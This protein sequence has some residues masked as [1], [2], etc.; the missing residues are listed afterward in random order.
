MKNLEDTKV[1]IMHDWLV[2]LGGAEKT[3]ECIAE[4]F[5]N[6]DIYTAKYDQKAV[7]GT[8]LED[9]NIIGPKQT[10]MSKVS[11]YFFTFLM[12]P[13]FEQFD[14]NKYDI[15]ISEGTAWPKGALTKPNQL[16]ISYIHTPPRFLYGY[17]TESTKRNKWYFK[18]FFSYI[19]NLLRI[20]DYVAAHRPDFLITNSQETRSRIKKF[21][22]LDAKVIYPPVETEPAISSDSVDNLPSKYYLCLGRLA[23]Y[24]RFDIAIEAFNDFDTPLVIVGTGG[25][26]KELKKLANKNIIFLGKLSESKKQYVMQHALGLIN[27][28]DDEDFGIVPVEMMANGKPVL[29]HKSAGHLETVKEGLNGAFYTEHNSQSLKGALLKFDAGIKNRMYNSEAIKQSVRQ[30]SID[31]FKTQFR[32]FVEDKYSSLSNA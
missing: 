13:I 19:D 23:S 4:I 18:L 14:L 9:R 17:S 2:Q 28:V 11:K 3:L 16:H 7:I 24:K 5:P 15:V 26:E 25:H 30:F 27:T 8:T 1:A 29:V 22:R 20:W 12:A 21:Y 31:S 10:W 32:K 6:A